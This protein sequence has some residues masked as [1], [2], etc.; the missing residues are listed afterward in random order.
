M[1]ALENGDD[2]APKEIRTVLAGVLM[3][4]T[5]VALDQSIVTPAFPAIARDLNGLE[6]LSWIVAAYLLTSTVLTLVYGKLS[7]VYGRRL[8]MLVA[9]A[10][11]SLA[12]L[13]CALSQSTLELILSRALQ[14][15]GAGGLIVTSQAAM[16]DLV[17]PRKRA[18]YQVYL[19]I[20]FALASASGPPLGGF[21]VDHFSWRWVFWVNVPIGA[22]AYLICRRLPSN[23]RR[24]TS[25]RLDMVGIAFLMAGVTMLL[26]AVTNVGARSSPLSAP[27]VSSTVL[28]VS[29][30]AAFIVRERKTDAPMF[31]PR[32]LGDATLRLGAI[33]VFGVAML[34]FG[35]IVVVPIFLQVVKGLGVGEAGVLL[36]PLLVGMAAASAVSSIVMRRSGHYKTLLVV[37]PLLS[38]G[39]YL[40]LATMTRSTPSAAVALIL[41]MLGFGIGLF[42]PTISIAVQNAAD[43]RDVGVAI[44]T[45]VFSRALG[46]AFGAAIF[47]TLLLAR[48]N[49]YLSAN[50]ERVFEGALSGNHGHTFQIFRTDA[51]AVLLLTR[52]FRDVFLCGSVLALTLFGMMIAIKNDVLK[53]SLPATVAEDG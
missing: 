15:A 44:S 40:E 35:A 8:L 32:L 49:R 24:S 50:G 12:S 22:A 7:D 21:F 28:A 16:A 33:G 25:G 38:T 11:F 47:W 30:L 1:S 2:S 52:A 10:L 41:A 29:F 27:V 43:L 45:M 36:V 48:S 18:S 3:L 9:I 39:A 13:L 26:L 31:P 4:V 6:Y 46:G 14:G 37:G 5:M 53:S 51:M 34:M 23:P 42:M 20:C 19:T 17:S